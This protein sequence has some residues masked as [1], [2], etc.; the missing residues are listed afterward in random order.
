[1]NVSTYFIGIFVI[2]I[3]IL[4]LKAI[5]EKELASKYKK[6]KLYKDLAKEAENKL[7]EYRYENRKKRLYDKEE[8]AQVIEKLKQ[9]NKQRDIY[10]SI[11]KE[12]TETINESEIIKKSSYQVNKEKGDM[13]EKYI[14]D[15]YREQGY[16][17]SEHG[18]DNGRKDKGIDVIA[19]KEKE[20]SE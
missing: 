3:V 6:K 2:I 14:A 8:T 12:E 5:T 15:Y 10:N 13:Y 16:T 17:I 4:F 19:K 7:K 18:Q 9:M 1:M 11:H 20:I